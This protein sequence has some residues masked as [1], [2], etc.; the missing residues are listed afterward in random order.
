MKTKH[1]SYEEDSVITYKTEHWN[2]DNANTGHSSS[3]QI[4]QQGGDQGQD[5]VAFSKE[6]NIGRLFTIIDLSA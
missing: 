5:N 6:G 2:P 3:L 4:A 1:S